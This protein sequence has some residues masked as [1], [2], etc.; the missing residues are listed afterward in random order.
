MIW[1]NRKDGAERIGRGFPL[2]PLG[3]VGIAPLAGSL[4]EC[5]HK[6]LDLDLRCPHFLFVGSRLRSPFNGDRYAPGD[7]AIV[8]GEA[9]LKNVRVAS[10]RFEGNFGITHASSLHASRRAYRS[11]AVGASVAQG[12][13]IEA[14]AE[15]GAALLS[16]S[17]S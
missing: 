16:I 9:E 15:S 8:C 3:P 12:Q 11:G 5:I 6:V 10:H 2:R 17:P 7:F 1:Y 13:L 14:A 4:A